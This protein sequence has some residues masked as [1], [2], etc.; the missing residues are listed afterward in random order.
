M[1]TCT[2]CG[3][4]LLHS[5]DTLICCY[6]HCGAYGQPFDGGVQSNA[7][8]VA[9]PDVRGAKHTNQRNDAREPVGP[10][11]HLAPLATA[12]TAAP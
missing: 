7:Q 11:E 10:H 4:P 8:P 5:N 1:S 9:S 3:R 2:E 6:R 12:W